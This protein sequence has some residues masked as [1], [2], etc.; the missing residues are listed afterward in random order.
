M[1][2]IGNRTN[3]QDKF[4]ILI[5]MHEH[6]NYFIIDVGMT[7][8]KRNIKINILYPSNTLINVGYTIY[9]CN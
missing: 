4:E 3:L 9:M 6:N 1:L 5:S 8:I 2:Y 7:Y